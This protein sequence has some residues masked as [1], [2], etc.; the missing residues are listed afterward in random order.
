ML[1]ARVVPPDV[2][3]PGSSGGTLTYSCN[4]VS[5]PDT[6]TSGEFGVRWIL[7]V[8]RGYSYNCIETVSSGLRCQYVSCGGFKGGSWHTWR[9]QLP[10][11]WVKEMRGAERLSDWWNGTHLIKAGCWFLLVRGL[12][13]IVGLLHISSNRD[14]SFGLLLLLFRGLHFHFT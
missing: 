4:T 9:P 14:I 6:T 3:R 5:H 1:A 2:S 7:S 13:I 10:V 12:F 8:V 11:Q